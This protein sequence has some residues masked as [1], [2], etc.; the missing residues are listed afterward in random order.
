VVPDSDAWRRLRHLLS[1]SDTAVR[2]NTCLVI[3]RVTSGNKELSRA[4]IEAGIVSA[5]IQFVADANPDIRRYAVPAVSN[6]TKFGEPE[7]VRTWIPLVLSLLE[8]SN[9]AAG[10]KELLQILRIS[11]SAVTRMRRCKGRR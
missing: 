8:N 2:E 9:S 6:A 4:A 3:L 10:T 11:L 1:S 5:I 7:E